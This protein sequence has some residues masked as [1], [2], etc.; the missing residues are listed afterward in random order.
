VNQ[1]VPPSKVLSAALA[2]AKGIVANS[3]DSVQSTKE[4]LLISQKLSF[5][6]TLLAHVASPPST[7]VY[8][9]ENIKVCVMIRPF[10]S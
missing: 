2:V 7:R 9:G 8:K 10:K 4:G 6:E 5:H 3:P 1:V